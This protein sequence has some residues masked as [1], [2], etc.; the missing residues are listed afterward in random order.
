MW[1]LIKRIMGNFCLFIITKHQQE[2]FY[3]EGFINLKQT[4]EVIQKDKVYN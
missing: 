1:D 4:Q 3:V 2:I